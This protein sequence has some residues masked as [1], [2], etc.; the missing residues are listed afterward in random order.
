MSDTAELRKYKD[1]IK[2]YTKSTPIHEV[3]QL[4]LLHLEDIM[5]I[6]IHK[7]LVELFQKEY[8][9]DTHLKYFS[10]FEDK[11]WAKEDLTN[12]YLKYLT[13]RRTDRIVKEILDIP[14]LFISLMKA[15]N[16][17]YENN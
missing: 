9:K 2:K 4:T 16:R 15:I 17:L 5:T 6:E 14:S 10:D 7:S 1:Y 13:E 11:I 3:I 12:E 8:L